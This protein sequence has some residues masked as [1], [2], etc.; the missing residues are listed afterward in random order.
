MAAFLVRA[1]GLTAGAGADL[2]T[3]DNGSIFE[4]DI[5]KLAT[6]GVTLGCAPGLFCPNGLVTRGEMAAF[7]ARILKLPNPGDVDLFVDDNGSTFESDIEKIAQAGI[8]LGCKAP[9]SALYCPNAHVTREQMAA[10]LHRA[11]G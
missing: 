2:F 6:A 4:A 7:L 11:Y 10:F 8:T 5:D 9:P 1:A 3:D